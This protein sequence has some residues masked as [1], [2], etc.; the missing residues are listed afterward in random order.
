[1]AALDRVVRRS[2]PVMVLGALVTALAV[3]GLATWALG[4]FGWAAP[5]FMRPMSAAGLLGIGIALLCHAREGTWRTS[6]GNVVALAVVSLGVATLGLRLLG[7]DSA[8]LGAW[9]DPDFYAPTLIAAGLALVGGSLAAGPRSRAS[10][11]LAFAGV[12]SAWMLVLAGAY[13]VDHVLASAMGPT[14]AAAAQGTLLLAAFGALL[15]HEELGVVAALTAR[16]EAGSALRRNLIAAAAIPS[17]FGLLSL[18]GLRA[19]LYD[20]RTGTAILAAASVTALAAAAFAANSGLRHAQRERFAGAAALA[21][22]EERV[23]RLVELAPVGIAQLAM[24]G[25]WLQANPKLCEMLGYTLQDLRSKTYSEVSQLEDLPLDIQSWELLRRGEIE[26]YSIERRFLSK[27]GATVYADVR[28]VRDARAVNEEVHFVAVIRDVTASK[29]FE[30]TLRVYERVIAATQSGIVI[31]DARLPD[32]PIISVNPAFERITGYAAADVLGKNPRFLSAK[33]RGQAGIGKLRRAIQAG[34]SCEVML[35]NHRANGEGFWNRMSVAPVHDA[36][37]RVTHFAGGLVDATEQVQL[38]AE[39]EALLSAADERRNAA[40]AANLAKEHLLSVVS[41]ELRSPMNAITGWA[42]LLRDER[43][44]EERV[45]AL[46]AI[47]SSLHAQTRLLDDLLDA[48]RLRTGALGIEFAEIDLVS[49]TQASFNRHLQAA[50]EKRISLGLRL[51]SQPATCY[52][53]AQRVEQILQNLIA[54]ALKF[55]PDGG[56]VS[57]E[58]GEEG[59]NWAILVH[60]SGRGLSP[61]ALPRVF[62]EFWQADAR[63]GRGLGIG[64]AIVKHLAERQ[65]GSVSVDSAGPGLGATFRVLLPKRTPTAPEATVRAPFDAAAPRD[66]SGAVVVVVDDEP[67]TVQAF[68]SALAKEGAIPQVANSVSAALSLLASTPDA[69]I[70]D[71]GLP[72]RDGF[73]LIRSVRSSADPAR[74]V[75]AIAVTA[76]S[77]REDRKRIFRAGFDT[78]FAKP[79][80]PQAVMRRL[81]ELRRRLAEET[82]PRRRL[83][84]LRD[85]RA[86]AAGLLAALRADG[87]EVIEVADASAAQVEASQRRPDAI[88]L[89]EPV[90][91]PSVAELLEHLES[92]EA[93]PTVVGLVEPGTEP[94]RCLSDLV[95]P[96]HDAGALRRALRLLEGVIR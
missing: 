36:D 81:S 14:P 6:A 92:V 19:D 90:H 64:L 87:H 51:P 44:P 11:Y 79:V 9:L 89:V 2:G 33:A 35:R 88:L 38:L 34:E 23:Q 25:R 61:E 32:Q 4:H 7:A 12:G 69:L 68:A 17:L 37:G 66:L 59:G 76:L 77:D 46:D 67:L 45:R 94:E 54:N 39:R 41:H 74:G 13:D 73:D 42:S 75:L 83:I 57:V 47:E 49:L 15:R 93:R 85:E 86:R 28:L 63:G 84:A 10:A 60:D 91:E 40:E 71:I 29:A 72:D 5:A 52:A 96:L 22:S 80:E 82:P 24:D 62:D 53:D 56:R 65:G 3:A 21:A 18:A 1:M 8:D 58:L 48:S 43:D 55:T 78:Y 70:S 95:V 30:D 50:H 27:E 16:D 20:D 26:D 31:T